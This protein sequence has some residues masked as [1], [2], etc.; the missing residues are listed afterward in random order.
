MNTKRIELR[1]ETQLHDALRQMATE[2]LRSVPMQIIT[3]LR[4]VTNQWN[5]ER[6]MRYDEQRRGTEEITSLVTKLNDLEN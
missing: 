3:I 1:V 2:E 4:A 5:I 6:K